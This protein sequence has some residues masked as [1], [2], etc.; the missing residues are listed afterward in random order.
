[1]VYKGKRSYG[2][3]KQYGRP[4]FGRADRKVYRIARNV[5]R[6]FT[7][8]EIK[9]N[10]FNKSNTAV[11]PTGFSDSIF[12]PVQGLTSKHRVGNSVKL[13][14]LKM[15]YILKM[16]ASA[17]QT[18]VRVIVLFDRQANTSTISIGGLLENNSSVDSFIENHVRYRIV[19]LYDR[20]HSFSISS[21][22]GGLFK[23]YKKL[24]KIIKFDGS[25]GSPTKNGL[26]VL[27]I[28][29]EA[30]NSPT[31]EYRTNMKYIDN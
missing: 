27:V 12:A 13:V 28:S 22:Q 7:N 20:T 3:K 30:T 29:D 21:T 15:N 16:H 25:T 19:K 1:M 17:T 18:N 14:G 2:N 4:M 31:I 23:I 6:K 10:F 26:V 11:T 8:A 24:D 5:V 9:S